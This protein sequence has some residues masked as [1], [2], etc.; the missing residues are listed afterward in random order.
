M[1]R[2]TVIQPGL[3]NIDFSITKNIQVGENVNLQF[4][5]EIF[6]LFDRANFSRANMRVDRSSGGR[7][8]STTLT[9]RQIQLGLRLTF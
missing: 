3:A 8:D 2:N 1:G 6:N 4:R 9:E 7:I 5:T